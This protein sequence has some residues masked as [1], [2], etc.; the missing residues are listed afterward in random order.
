MGRPLSETDRNDVDDDLLNKVVG[1]PLQM[2]KFAKRATKDL[3]NVVAQAKE[4][5]LLSTGEKQK[6]NCECNI[7]SMLNS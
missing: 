6:L 1:S 2:F 4:Q 7:L 3:E 5:L